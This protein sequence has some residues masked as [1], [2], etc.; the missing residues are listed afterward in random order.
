MNSFDIIM[1]ARKVL[2]RLQVQYMPRYI[3]AHHSITHQ[4]IDIWGR[5]NDECDREAKS[6]WQ[7]ED[8]KWT[9]VPYAVR[10]WQERGLDNEELQ[11]MVDIEAQ[12]KAGKAVGIP[13][14][15]WVMKHRHGMTGTGHYMKQWKYKS[16]AK[17]PHCGHHDETARHVTK[18]EEAGANER[19][20]KSIKE[21]G[22]DM[23]G[24]TTHAPKAGVSIDFL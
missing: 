10:K 14:R 17:C 3:P 19:C 24:E 11:D 7:D 9:K 4:E 8:D 13:R 6:F 21:V 23:D 22:W 12:R 15:L 20:N 18:C 2:T 5:A 1:A 16:T